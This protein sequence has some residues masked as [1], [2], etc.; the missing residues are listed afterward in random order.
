M[1]ES[2][3]DLKCSFFSYVP[4]KCVYLLKMYRTYDLCILLCLCYNI[5][6][7]LL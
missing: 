3:G 1:K 2:L 4:V 5:I 6:Q 7:I